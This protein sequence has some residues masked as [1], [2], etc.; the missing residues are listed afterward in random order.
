MTD[1]IQSNE[2]TRKARF[3]KIMKQSLMR[4]SVPRKDIEATVRKILAV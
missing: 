2:K 3:E 1:G 4:W